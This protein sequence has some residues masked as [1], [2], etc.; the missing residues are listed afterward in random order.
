MRDFEPD[1]YYLLASGPLTPAAGLP[2]QNLGRLGWTWV[3][4]FDPNSQTSG[5]LSVCQ[6]QIQA[7]RMLHT[8]VKGERQRPEPG[9]GHLLVLRPRHGRAAEHAGTGAVARVEA[10]L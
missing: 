10:G 7:Q 1:Y 8:V 4:D 5:L 2:L 9:P 6:A 3:A